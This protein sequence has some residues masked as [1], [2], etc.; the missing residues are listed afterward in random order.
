MFGIYN[1][2]FDSVSESANPEYFISFLYVLQSSA[3]MISNP[4]SPHRH[5]LNERW[6]KIISNR[7]KEGMNKS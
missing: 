1:L 6:N 5:R 3:V 2:L 4:F 7:R